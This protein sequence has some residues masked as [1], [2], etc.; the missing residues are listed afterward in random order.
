MSDKLLS[1]LQGLTDSQFD[2]V[3]LSVRVLPANLPGSV[4]PLT[5]RAIALINPMKQRPEGLVHL[6]A[7]V[8]EKGL[9]I[10]LSHAALTIVAITIIILCLIGLVALALCLLSLPKPQGGKG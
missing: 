1:E 4:S 9:T 10:S 7:A 5:S 6:H 2:A 8:R 3:V